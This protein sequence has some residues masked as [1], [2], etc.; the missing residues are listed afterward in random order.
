MLYA[1][2]D[3]IDS[4]SDLL[5]LPVKDTILY[6]W[7]KVE[8]PGRNGLPKSISAKIHPMLQTSAGLPYV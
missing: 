8:F 5:G 4:T 1:K 3:S 2:G 6:S 7:F